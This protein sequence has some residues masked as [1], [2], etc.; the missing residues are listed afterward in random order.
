M[1]SLKYRTDT[2]PDKKTTLSYVEAQR[3][4]VKMQK[5]D[6]RYI[7]VEVTRRWHRQSSC[8]DSVQ[9]MDSEDKRSVFESVSDTQRIIE[10]E[11]CSSHLRAD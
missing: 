11:R 3:R 1:F 8:V 5:W 6:Q 7:R 10:R 4:S 2:L 9:P